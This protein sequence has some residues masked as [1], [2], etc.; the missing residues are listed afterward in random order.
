MVYGVTFYRHGE[1]RESRLEVDACL[2]RAD[3]DTVSCVRIYI[4]D[5]HDTAGHSPL[6]GRSR[7]R[8][9]H[10]LVY[11]TCD[12]A[13]LGSSM[14]ALN[15][16][17]MT[18]KASQSSL[19]ESEEAVDWVSCVRIYIKDTHDTAGH[20]PLTGRSR[21]RGGHV[22]VYFTC[23]LATLGSSMAAL[24]TIYMTSKA[25]QSSL[26]ESEEAVDWVSCVRIYIKD[27]H[28]TAGHSPLTGRSR[29]RGGHVLVYF[30]CDLAT[31][32][33][34]VVLQQFAR[35]PRTSCVNPTHSHLLQ[36]EYSRYTLQC[37]V[38]VLG[39]YVPVTSE[40]FSVC[41]P[42]VRHGDVTLVSRE[43]ACLVV[44]IPWMAY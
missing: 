31:M 16:I 5:T 17:Y 30:T 4:K 42:G 33:I 26:S 6:T 24:N 13:T 44:E 11:F 29:R 38:F 10:V 36:S 23:D 12:L 3:P 21:R 18:S 27:T 8:G 15:T 28:D 25:S 34:I 39:G 19:S 35:L 41:C 1:V 7:R 32:R 20:S 9:G 43:L 37:L 2:V 14:A 40:E 22:L